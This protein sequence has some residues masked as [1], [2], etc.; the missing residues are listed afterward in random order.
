ND[1]ESDRCEITINRKTATDLSVK[2]GAG[3]GNFDLTG[4]QLRKV[5]FELGAGEFKINVSDSPLQVF[6]LAAGVGEATIDFGGSWKHNLKA[7]FKC[8]IG[9]LKI[10]IP[11]DV[12]VS[13]EL[14]GLLGSIDAPSFTRHSRRELSYHGGDGF[15]EIKMY[16]QGG[17]G[18]I[19]LTVD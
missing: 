4:I 6:N 14:N 16:I 19:E 12:N 8:G 17:L 1:K 3:E 13:V 11:N 5:N 10:R 18:N 9:E 7:N 2:F 15:P